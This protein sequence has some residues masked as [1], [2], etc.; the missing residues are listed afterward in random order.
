M[1]RRSAAL[2]PSPLPFLLALA[3]AG[4]AHALTVDE[5]PDPR[6]RGRVVDLARSIPE[7]IAHRLDALSQAVAAQ[8]KGEIAVVVVRSTDGKHPRKLALDL[9]NSWW[10]GTSKRNDGI[11]L[12]AAI[13][14]RAAE[15]ILGDDVDDPSQQ[16]HSDRIMQEIMVPR[17][18]Q[19]Q[20][21]QAMLEGALACARDILGADV[22]A[23]A[24]A[25]VG[26]TVDAVRKGKPAP[27]ARRV[28]RWVERQVQWLIGSAVALGLVGLV[29]ARAVLRRR[30]RRCPRCRQ[31]MERLGEA[32]DDRFLDA[33]EKRE[34]Q[35]G[36]VDYDIWYCAPCK[37]SIKVRYGAFFT[38]Y[39]KC[40]KCGFKTKSSSSTT[41]RAATYDHGGTVRVDEDCRNCSYKNSYTRSTPRRQRPTSSSRSSSSYRSSSSSRSSFSSRSSSSSSRSSGGGSSGR[42]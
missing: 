20:A 33:G 18:R 31:P 41:L 26:P 14:D 30:P 2:L 8:G 10:L 23:A 38:S 29:V 5:I 19:G 36:S 40:P 22:S 34:E 7:S 6:P 39:G 1:N 13:D 15:I 21:A 28:Q 25:R 42:W 32:A 4:P 16:T 11:L 27:I 3:L 24:L 35:L 37:Q 9:F 12:F 17:F